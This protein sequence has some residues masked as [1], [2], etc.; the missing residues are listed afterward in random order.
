MIIDPQQLSEEAVNNLISEYCLRD[1]GLN[2]CDS[3]LE[4][5]Q[6]QVKAALKSGQL[7]IIYSQHHECAQIIA[8]TEI[9]QF[10]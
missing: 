4:N 9:S 7:V 8:A 2:D 1:W 6:D 5:H 10:S 3:S